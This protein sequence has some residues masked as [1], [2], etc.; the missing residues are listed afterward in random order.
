MSNESTEQKGTFVN[1]E[2]QKLV[3]V[4]A[5]E[6]KARKLNTTDLM[7]L[8]SVVRHFNKG[9]DYGWVAYSR[10]ADEAICGERTVFDAMKRLVKADVLS[11]VGKTHTGENYYRLNLTNKHF[12]EGLAWTKRKAEERAKQKPDA[13]QLQNLPPL[14]DTAPSADTAPPCGNCESGPAVAAPPSAVTAPPSAVSASGYCGNRTQEEISETFS[15]IRE[16]TA[17]ETGRRSLANSE[18]Q[19]Q[20]KQEEPAKPAYDFDDEEP[21]Q[22]PKPVKPEPTVQAP[23]K[24]VKQ[25]PALKPTGKYAAGQPVNQAASQPTP[26]TP[27]QEL[28]DWYFELIG[29]PRREAQAAKTTWA[30]T[31]NSLISDRGIDLVKQVMTWA[32]ENLYWSDKLALDYGD[33]A[34]LVA[35]KFSMWLDQRAADS[36]RASRSKKP[37]QS[38]APIAQPQPTYNRAIFNVADI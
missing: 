36:E 18:T 31:F 22:T 14:A 35:S 7:V 2:M 6:L 21:E 34:K 13:Y 29:S 9:D 24:P 27:A 28:A 37:A 25:R 10:I 17:A 15:E 5:P 19:D 3:Q 32:S 20:V 38:S 23:A 16:E 26:I 12:E 33:S 1:W 4:C 11:K 30:S 8:L